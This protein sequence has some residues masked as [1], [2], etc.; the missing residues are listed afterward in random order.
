V[1]EIGSHFK[2]GKHRSVSSSIER[3]E[4]QLSEDRNP[5]NRRGK[6]SAQIP[7]RQQ[8]VAQ[9]PFRLSENVLKT[10]QRNF[11]LGNNP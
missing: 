8:A 7:K 5:K 9:I 1:K 2:M 3:M 10:A 11:Y 4:K 6:L